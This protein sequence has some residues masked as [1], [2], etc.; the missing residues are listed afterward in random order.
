MPRSVILTYIYTKGQWTSALFWADAAAAAG[1]REGVASGDDMWLLA[2]AMLARGELHRAAHT[3]TSRGLH[4]QHLLCLGVAARAL[5][6]AQEPASALN[7]IEEC[8]SGLLESRTN[9]QT[10]NV[11]V[12]LSILI[13][14]L[15]SILLPVQPSILPPVSVPIWAKAGRALGGILVTRAR[16]L[17]ALERRDAAAEA[18]T[19]ALRADVACYEALD[20]LLDQHALTAAQAGGCK[21]AVAFDV[22]ASKKRRAVMHT[23][24]ML[25]EKVRTIQ[26]GNNIEMYNNNR[27]SQ[28]TCFD[29]FRCKCFHKLVKKVEEYTRHQSSSSLWH[30][31][32]FGRITASKAYEVKMY[33]SDGSLVSLI[34]GGNI[35]E[36]PAMK[37]GK[38]KVCMK[39]NNALYLS[40]CLFGQSIFETTESITFLLSLEECAL[41]ESLPYGSL[42]EAEAAF[43]KTAYKDRLRRYLPSTS[44]PEDEQLQQKKSESRINLVEMP[45]LHNMCEVTLKDRGRNSEI[46]KMLATRVE[47]KS[48]LRWFG[49]LERMN[50]VH[51]VESVRQQTAEARCARARR[52]A[53]TC[54][55]AAALKELD[56]VDPWCCAE[57]RTACLVELRKSSELFAFAHTLVDGYPNSWTA[58][59]SVGCYY[60]LIGKNELARRYLS[61][62]K[63]LEPSAG[64]VW[65]AY[66]HSFA[67][68][69]EHDQA[70]AAYF[71]ASQLMG[72]CHIP[73][74]YVGVEC[75]LLN[76]IPMAERFL[77]RAAEL[78]AKPDTLNEACELDLL[79]TPEPL[80][81]GGGS[82]WMRIART[83]ADAQVAH[84]AGAAAFACREYAAAEALW[85]RALAVAASIAPQGEV[86]PR[87][88]PTLDALG[89]A[90][91][92]LGRPG[93]AL[94]WHEKAL[95]CR[96]GRASTY[97]AI[98]LCLAL[99][100]RSTAAADALHTALAKDPD[101]AVALGLLDAIV[102]KLDAAVTNFIEEETPQFPFPSV[103]LE[104][105]SSGGAGPAAAHPATGDVTNTSDMSM[106]FD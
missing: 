39:E 27:I 19:A 54:E 29:I 87:W 24:T 21:H 48:I 60:Y 45:S 78:H 70:M 7:L 30:E 51:N 79:S 5:L 88:A 31:L 14:V 66:G 77:A 62:S 58:W 102:A 98:G 90:C 72:G 74:L 59:F 73:A 22:V 52:L 25:L 80:P 9:D 93:E 101:D 104:L 32:R 6:A 68:D 71:K 36:T 91:R 85:S 20:L 76:N 84:E 41:V 105:P 26:G 2:S 89:H 13:L 99:L 38:D 34:M 65:L 96:P 47:K 92:K 69:N 4:R 81:E 37:R 53:A 40:I 17:S 55:W 83:A 35:P 33:K 42:S 10:H 12:P 67:A 97:T 23:G 56:T 28:R 64:C 103:A 100:G 86:G 63:S 11:P 61:K 46:L 75:A 82:G 44:E 1:G 18:L 94:N 16:A 49:H 3:V 8:D 57:V 95:S 106:S 15:F 50:I 43:I